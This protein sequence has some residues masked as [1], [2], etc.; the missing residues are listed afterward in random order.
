MSPLVSS[1]QPIGFSPRRVASTMPTPLD[2]ARASGNTKDTHNGST[3]REVDASSVITTAAMAT[4]SPNSTQ[5]AIRCTRTRRSSPPRD[6]ATTAPALN[7]PD[8][9]MRFH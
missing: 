9:C 4:V 1:S 3:R 7:A 6:P 8:A 2:I 5:G